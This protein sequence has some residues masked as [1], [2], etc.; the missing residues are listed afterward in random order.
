MPRRKIAKT[1]LVGLGG[2]GNLALKYAKKRFHEMYGAGKSYDD[3]D[4]PLIQYLALDTDIADLKKGIGLNIKKEILKTN[5]CI[6]LKVSQPSQVLSGNPYIEREWMPKKNVARLDA[7]EA[8][9]GQIRGFGRLG[10]MANFGKIKTAVQSKINKLNSWENDH[11]SDFEATDEAINVVFC[12]SVS[13]GTG[14]GT[15]IDMAYLVKDCLSDS[16]I[17]F[18]SQAYIIL[19]EIF[20]KVIK[21]SI[22][23]KRIWSNSYGALR[24]LEFF[25]EGKYNKNIELLGDNKMTIPVKG[26]PFNL[27]HLISDKNTDGTD[28]TEI[29]HM[30]ELIGSSVV[31]K[32]GDLATAGKSGWD[33][34]ERDLS[35]IEYLDDNN[36]QMPRYLG[37]GYAEIQYNTS[38]VSEVTSCNL[39]AKLSDLIIDSNNRETDVSIEQRVIVWGIKED[40]ADELLEQL[41]PI[42]SYRNYVV[43]GDGYEG[44]DTRSI[45]EANAEAHLM[46]EIHQLKN[47]SSDNLKDLQDRLIKQIIDDIIHVEGCILNKGGIVTAINAIDRLLSEP[48]IAR[49]ASQMHDEIEN[50]F[51]G[52]GNGVKHY[53]NTTRKRIAEELSSLSN[54]QD[55]M[56]FVKRA[57]CMPVIESLI[58][59]YNNLIMY[60]ADLIKREDAKQFYAKLSTDLEITKQKLVTMKFELQKCKTNFLKKEGKIKDNIKNESRKPFTIELH[61]KKIE[62]ANY[63]D[64]NSVQLS[65]FLKSMKINLSDFINMNST[66]ITE[67]IKL[68]ISGT[69]TIEDIK[70]ENLTTYLEKLEDKDVEGIFKKLKKMSL[71]LQSIVKDKFHMKMEDPDGGG[72]SWTETSLWGIAT[73]KKE[74]YKLIGSHIETEPKILETGDHSF[75]MSSTLYYPAPALSLTNIQRY[76]DAYLNKRSKVSFDTDRRIREAMDDANFDLIPKDVADTKTLFAWIFGL[77]LYKLTDKEDGIYR[78]GAGRFLIKSKTASRADKHWLDLDTAWRN[79]AFAKF[80]DLNLDLEMLVKIND[81][82]TNNG[83]EKI[84]E[85]IEEIKHDYSSKYISDY[86]ALNRSWDDLK[87]SNDSRSEDVMEMM[88]ME[89]DFISTL[90]IE[91]INDYL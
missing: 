7:I 68:F 79:D 20:D 39:S 91:S 9:A 85:I 19:P 46:N 25:M 36:T 60:N 31:F 76:Y 82:I 62:S 88:N 26:A 59:S 37:L 84:T 28:Y 52:L 49:Y 47:K 86:S 83:V 73:K 21:E 65:L 16:S 23:K 70:A 66:E 4:L 29:Q 11:N 51:S 12:F 10:L 81:Y 5:E 2:T 80:S 8:G 3:F 38:L 30:M 72:N 44:S 15:F 77:V 50:N 34:I 27:V 18:T 41:L 13:G 42:N 78:K 1:L 74:V 45:L 71:P 22:G 53:I 33:N 58:T 90:S 14:S 54:A 89:I 64:E 24:E 35:M 48:F 75:V 69:L 57:N 32:S 6:H 40:L 17:D 61:K 63:I 55:T 67:N 43:E 56:I 87:S